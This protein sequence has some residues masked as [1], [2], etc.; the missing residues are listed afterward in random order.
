MIGKGGPKR[1]ES[2][3]EKSAISETATGKGASKEGRSQE[4]R[5]KCLRANH[6]KETDKRTKTGGD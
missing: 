6:H 1:R 5:E 3:W 4:K 2:E